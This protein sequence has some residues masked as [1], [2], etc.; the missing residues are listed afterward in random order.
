[1]TEISPEVKEHIEKCLDQIRGYFN[2][3]ALIVEEIKPDDHKPATIICADLASELG[4][5]YSMLYQVL[6]LLLTKEYPGVLISKGSRGGVYKLLI[7]ITPEN[8]SPPDEK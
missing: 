8:L 3:A 2:Q 1:M 6:R 4:V 5:S 7:K